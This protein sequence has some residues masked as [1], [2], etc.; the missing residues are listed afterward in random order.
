M[1]K[2]SSVLALEERALNAWPALQTITVEGWLLRLAGGCTKRANSANAMAPRGDMAEVRRVAEALYA[3]HGLPTVFRLTP[4]APRDAE[5]ELAQAG[6]Q[7][8]DPSIVLGAR[9]DAAHDHASV[10]IDD[11]PSAPWLDGICR[12]NAVTG[13]FR[14]LHDAVVGS[15]AW[16]AAFATLH[17]K[18]SPL[19]F[20]L[21]V[22]E[23]GLV[24]LFDI[25]V[26]PAARGRG[27]GATL[28]RALMGWGAQMGARGA[29]LQVRRG[30]AP[31][32]RLYAS[33][34]FETAYA[35]H[36]RIRSA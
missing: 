26:D 19:G 35:Y 11:Q 23:R 12:A 2:R 22:Q 5:A 34:G 29:Y 18:G 32:E 15:I 25:V 9:L 21:A 31:A 4:L 16:P 20:G 27:H 8:A 14:P 7:V 13:A 33:L 24:G 17:D 36:Y 30:N 10:R 3:R 28:T 6:Y 1:L